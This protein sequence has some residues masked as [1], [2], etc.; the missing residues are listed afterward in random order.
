MSDCGLGAG[1]SPP[2]LPWLTCAADVGHGPTVLRRTTVDAR[3]RAALKPQRF[4]VRKGAT[5]RPVRAPSAG[6]GD[7]G[8]ESANLPASSSRVHPPRHGLKAR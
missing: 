8:N 1:L 7:A 4:R 6:T 5:Y 3:A 2:S